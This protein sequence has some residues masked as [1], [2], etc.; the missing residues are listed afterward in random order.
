MIG[1]DLG[2]T[3]S[4][5]Y[6][7]EPTSHEAVAITPLLPSVVDYKNNVVGQDAKQNIITRRSDDVRSSFKVDIQLDYAR[8]A[9]AKVLAELA[10]YFPNGEKDVVISV[11]AY[12]NVVQRQQTI[13][14]AK[15]A[16]LNVRSL[17]NE[18][19]AA[20]MFYN[21]S[22]KCNTIVYDLGGG[23]FDISV[24]DSRFGRFDVMAT[25]GIKL[26][27][28]DLD[29]TLMNGIMNWG[30]F[31]RH[32]RN[33][34]TI[35]PQLKEIAESLKLHIQKH[36]SAT[37]NAADYSLED[38]FDKPVF[39]VAEESYKNAL[40][41]AFGKTIPRTERVIV[42]SMFAKEELEFIFVGGSTRDPY[43]RQMIEEAISMKAAELTYNPDHIVGQGAAYFAYLLSTGEAQDYVSDV[44]KALGFQLGDG[45]ILNLIPNNSQIPVSVKR[46]VTNDKKASGVNFSVYQGD[47]VLASE[48]SHIGD[49][50]Y[51]FEEGE[52][53]AKAAM[54]TITL[55]VNQSGLL[56]VRAKEIG[57]L[58]QKVELVL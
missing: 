9:S 48:C 3:N 45:T 22:N 35:E 32:V 34:E 29:R 13:A 16:G 25:D 1:I 53:E 40:K 38:C 2:T 10:K 46:V 44:T 57:C 52:Q 19:T 18:P 51:Q 58:E 15:L 41:L 14:A 17:I 23:T 49:L 24:I 42:E 12:F 21:R 20:A 30:K 54:V 11:P 55:E 8:D 6:K 47:S 37:F 27:G 50:I 56:T 28:D 31:K 5:A 39:E 26:G 4:V 36:G 43:L 33:Y 7:W